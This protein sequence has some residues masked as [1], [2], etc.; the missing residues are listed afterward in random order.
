MKTH[1][2]PVFRALHGTALVLSP[3]APFNQGPKP[4][5]YEFLFQLFRQFS[6][7]VNWLDAIKRIFDLFFTLL[8]L[9]LLFPALFLICLIIKLESKGSVF[10][11]PLREGKDGSVFPCFKFRTMYADQC[12]NPGSGCRSTIKNDPRITFFGRFLR[13]YSLDE[14]PQLF[15]VVRGEMSLVGPR[16][17]RVSLGRE[18][19][20]F[21]SQYDE[22]HRVRPGITGWAQVNGWRGATETLQQRSE[23]IRHD[24]WYVRNWNILLDLKIIWLT[25]F[26]GG[27]V[28][29]LCK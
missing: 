17:H 29:P 6:I 19:R 9:T 8:A 14:L 10:Y 20:N 21:D 1:S 18:L 16:P 5:F 2:Y 11:V 15:N 12:D 13:K 24:V 25:V 23:R 28:D 7:S 26:H 4:S 27:L 3:A 22:R